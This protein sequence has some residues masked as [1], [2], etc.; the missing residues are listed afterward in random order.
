MTEDVSERGRT[1]REKQGP[2]NREKKLLTWDLLCWDGGSRSFY[3]T[4]GRNGAICI[5][6]VCVCLCLC[7]CVLS[8]CPDTCVQ[9]Y[10]H[11]YRS[12]YTALAVLELTCFCLP[13]VDIKGVGHHALLQ[14][15]LRR[16]LAEPEA[17]PLRLPSQG[18]PRA[19]L[20]LTVLELG[21]I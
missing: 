9:I 10:K 2:E 8:T 15:F 11:V 19:L 16:S 3:T 14:C 1:E 7:V 18:V 21:L 17:H 5:V 4:E 6:C 13:G 20:P 12:H